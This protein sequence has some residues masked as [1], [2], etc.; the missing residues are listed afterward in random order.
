MTQGTPQKVPRLL[1]FWRDLNVFIAAFAAVTSFAGFALFVPVSL[2]MKLILPA[3]QA[4]LLAWPVGYGLVAVFLCWRWW[5]HGLSPRQL[6]PARQTRFRLG[7][8]LLAFF[9]VTKVAMFL[10]ASLGIYSLLSRMPDA[11]RM[12][13]GLTSLAPM[14]LLAGLVMVLSAR[15]AAPTFADTLPGAQD[16]VRNTPSAKW[17]PAPDPSGSAPSTLIVLA[18]LIVSSL[19]MYMPWM[20]AAFSFASQKEFFSNVVLPIA[21]GVYAAYVITAFALLAMRHGSATWVAWA[22]VIFVTVA[23]P[24]WQVVAMLI[25]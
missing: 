10:G 6:N 3:R 8:A 17:P 1:P 2:V 13:F 4:E 19:M 20:F 15:G 18:G 25:R 7:H 23:A 5:K 9:N 14:G 16:G 24:L 22:P 21:A 12:I 11:A